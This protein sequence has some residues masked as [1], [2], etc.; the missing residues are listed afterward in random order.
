[1]KFLK[2]AIL[3]LLV[4]CIT[5]AVLVSAYSSP[6][7]YSFTREL[8]KNTSQWTEWRTKNT[9]TDQAYKNR[10]TYTW[11]TDPCPNCKVAAKPVDGDGDIY[12]GVVTSEGQTKTFTDTTAISAP[13]DFRLS[14]WRVDV[15]LLTTAHS[16]TWTIN[17]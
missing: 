13:N 6:S 12:S 15:T 9:W 7:A 14:I 2:Y 3:T 5:D 8:S 4:A 10:R 1:M 16:A 17:G 11:M